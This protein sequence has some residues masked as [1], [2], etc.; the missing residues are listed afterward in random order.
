MAQAVFTPKAETDLTAIALSVA[1][2]N[3]ERTITF[4]R[5]IIGHCDRIANR[6]DVGRLRPDVGLKVHSVPH[7]RYVIFYIV[8]DAGVEIMHLLHGARDIRERF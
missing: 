4:T 6:P 5:E 2:R 1:R 3:P 8:L 7:G